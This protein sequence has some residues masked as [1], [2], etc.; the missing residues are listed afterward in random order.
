LDN[1]A[2]A[3]SVL[4]EEFSSL[5]LNSVFQTQFYRP[6]RGLISAIGGRPK[7]DAVELIIV[8]DLNLSS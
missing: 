1:S 8:E 6:H 3:F 7:N 2:L 4:C 5:F